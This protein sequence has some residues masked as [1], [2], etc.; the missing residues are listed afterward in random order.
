MNLVLSGPIDATLRSSITEL[1]K[2][3]DIVRLHAAAE[4]FEHV[5][6]TPDVRTAVAAACDA[7]R[8]DHAFVPEGARLSDFRLLAMDMDS[9]LIT[10]ECID[11]LADLAGKGAEVAAITAAA[12]R[13]EITDFAESLRRRVALLRGAPESLLQR[14][15]DERLK[16]TDGATELVAAAHACGVRTLLLSGG[17][18]FFAEALQ[19]R[20]QLSEIRANQLEIRGGVLTGGLIGPILDG[21]AKASA[22][23]D[24]LKQIHASRRQA[25][26]IGDGANDIPMMREVDT[27]VAFHAK[28]ITETVSSHR[29]RYGSL[30]AVLNFY[31]E[32]QVFS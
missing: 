19:R 3:A 6:D 20:L 10:I 18:T 29:I 30:S 5:I 21:T 28:P 7:A 25:L 32:S 1:T 4:R 9:T 24:S 11:E 2:P 17:F 31:G 26:V 22:V 23:A 8:V 16:L 15:L 14:V 13:G 12:M 27:S